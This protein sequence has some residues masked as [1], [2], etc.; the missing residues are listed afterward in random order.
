MRVSSDGESL[1]RLQ[2]VALR[3]ALAPAVTITDRDAESIEQ[4]REAALMIQA[5]TSGAIARE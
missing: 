1:H 2:H 3:G 4:G 5:A